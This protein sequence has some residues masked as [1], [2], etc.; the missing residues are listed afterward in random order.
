MYKK[1]RTKRW[2]RDC[3]VVKMFF[4]LGKFVDTADSF[5]KAEEQIVYVNFNSNFIFCSN[6]DI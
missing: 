3:S 1:K 4:A 2:R 6:V 5:N